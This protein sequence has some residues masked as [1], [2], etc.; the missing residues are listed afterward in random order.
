MKINFKIILPSASLSGS[1]YL[2][3]STA[4]TKRTLMHIS[5]YVD[6]FVLIAI[7]KQSKPVVI[8]KTKKLIYYRGIRQDKDG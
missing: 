1:R 3:V 2:I 7:S 5:L 4:G 8:K 6:L